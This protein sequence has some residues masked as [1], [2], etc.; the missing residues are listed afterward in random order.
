MSD[1]YSAQYNYSHNKQQTY[2]S[3]QHPTKQEEQLQRLRTD[4]QTLQ[5]QLSK[6]HAAI[7]LRLYL[8]DMLS[9]QPTTEQIEKWLNVVEAV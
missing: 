8:L 2:K 4:H 1:W 7:H 9:F 3:A 5:T 6:H